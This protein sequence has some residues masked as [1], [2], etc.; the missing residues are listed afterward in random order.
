MFDIFNSTKESSNVFTSS[1]SQQNSEIVLQFLDF[2]ENYIK[3]IK[4]GRVNIL[5]TNERTGFKGLLI[6]IDSLKSLYNLCV[7][8]GLRKNISTFQ[9]SQDLLESLF[10]RIRSANGNND[11]PDITQFISALR[12]ILINNEIKSSALANCEDKLQIMNISSRRQNTL[13]NGIELIACNIQLPAD[14]SGT[15]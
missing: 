7:K 4:L 11:N 2:A 1:L 8:P 5:N 13:D 10:G 14:C 9:L 6:N 12:N 3:S 15:Q